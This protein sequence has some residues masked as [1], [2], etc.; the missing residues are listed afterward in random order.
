MSRNDPN[1]KAT[2]MLGVMLKCLHGGPSVIISI[3]PVHKLTSSYKFDIVKEN[4]I[5]VEMSYGIV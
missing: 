3:T 1:T 5:S 4:A 2:A